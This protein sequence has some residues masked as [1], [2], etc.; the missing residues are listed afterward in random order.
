LAYLIYLAN[1]NSTF[2]FVALAALAESSN[3]SVT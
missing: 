2:F 3:L 1:N